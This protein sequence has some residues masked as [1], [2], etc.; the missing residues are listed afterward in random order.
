[1]I[2]GETALA[3]L[4][5]G[6]LGAIEVAGPGVDQ[7][8][9][10]GAGAPGPTRWASSR[11]PAPTSTPRPPR[12]LG[13]VDHHARRRPRAPSQAARRRTAQPS[14]NG[15]MPTVS[16]PNAARLQRGRPHGDQGSAGTIQEGAVE[17]GPAVQRPVLVR[18]QGRPVVPRRA[19]GDADP[20]RRR[21]RRRPTGSSTGS[22]RPSATRRPTRTCS[23]SSRTSSRR[24]WPTRGPGPWRSRRRSRRS[25]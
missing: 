19:G 20:G 13:R 1:M 24:C 16:L 4:V 10:A 7:P 6:G 3:E 17:D 23:R 11:S 2:F 25:T 15:A 9:S 22:A 8:S 21:G 14:L 18:P 12:P 5:D